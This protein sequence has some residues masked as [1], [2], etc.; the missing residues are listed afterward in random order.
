MA[1][2]R[3]LVCGSQ[4]F[5]DRSFV[6]SVL[7]AFLARLNVGAVISGPFDGADSLAR[8][9]AMA[10]QIPHHPLDLRPEDLRLHSFFDSRPIPKS[11]LIN[12]ALTMRGAKRLQS[13]SVDAMLAI[14]RPS[15][16]LGPMATNL[17]HIADV[18]EIP[19][20][21]GSDAFARAQV[22]FE[23]SSAQAPS[24]RRRHAGP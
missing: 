24:A 3:L 22:A 21:N 11:V 8:E 1:S 9:W 2:A 5:D 12:D 18:L 10:R 19:C 15:G 23:R 16:Q 6:Y 17:M 14:P 4:N 13:L 7:D 20:F